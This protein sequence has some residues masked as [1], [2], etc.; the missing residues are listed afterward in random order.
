MI[1]QLWIEFFGKFDVLLCP[2]MPCTAF[3]HDH[4]SYAKRT[5]KINGD[6]VSYVKALLPWAGLI[7][8]SD[9]P[10]TVVPIGRDSKN[11]PF[12][13]QI[14]AAPWQDLQCIEVGKMLE[15]LGFRFEPPPAYGQIGD[16]AAK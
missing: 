7:I 9:L 12:G 2:I 1:K 13:M 5:L 11:L 6:T 3:P 8:F 4:T 15:R 16:A 10:S 14:V